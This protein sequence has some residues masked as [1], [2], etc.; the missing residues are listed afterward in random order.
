MGGSIG[1][2]D[3]TKRLG[4]GYVMNQIGNNGAAR[5]LTATYRSLAT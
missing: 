1:L 5:L 3:P 4:F 2:A